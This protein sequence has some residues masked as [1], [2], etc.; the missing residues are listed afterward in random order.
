MVDSFFDS[1]KRLQ[2]SCRTVFSCLNCQTD[3]LWTFDYTTWSN[4][5]LII[6]VWLIKHRYAIYRFCW[7]VQNVFSSDKYFC[8][9][10]LQ[11]G[12]SKWVYIFSYIY[13]LLFKSTI[14]IY[15]TWYIDWAPY[16]Q[17]SK[18]EYSRTNYTIIANNHDFSKLK[19][20]LQPMRR[21]NYFF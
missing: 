11:T 7:F 21:F 2:T 10:D 1:K 14:L 13:V 12:N 9:T 17:W 18:I 19:Q 6:I 3:E 4:T 15:I 16:L 20:L 8:S 5:H